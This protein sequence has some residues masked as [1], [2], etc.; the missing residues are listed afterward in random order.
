MSCEDGRHR[1]LSLPAQHQPQASQPLVEVG[2]DVR[3]LLR[4]GCEL[5]QQTT[6]P[7]KNSANNHSAQVRLS[8][9]SRF[10]KKK[11]WILKEVDIIGIF[12]HPYFHWLKPIPDHDQAYTVF[13][14]LKKMF[15]VKLNCNLEQETSQSPTMASLFSA[16][17]FVPSC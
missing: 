5:Q 14:H 8:C 12:L 11:R 4:L 6:Q 17:H 7:Y 1:Q 9:F 13:K 10:L 15:F 3:G 2:H 16:C